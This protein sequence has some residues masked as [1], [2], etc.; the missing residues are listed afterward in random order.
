[1]AQTMSLSMAYNKICAKL[2]PHTGARDYAYANAED[3]AEAWAEVII[4]IKALAPLAMDCLW[5]SIHF[6]HPIQQCAQQVYYTAIPLSPTSSPLYKLSFQKVIYNQLS[7]ITTFSGAPD[8]WGLLLRTIDVRPRQLTCIATSGQRIIAACEEVVNIYNAITFVLQQSLCASETVTKITES[9]DGSTLFFAH[10]FTVTMWDVQTGG[11]INTFTVQS[12]IQDVAISA[13]HIACGSSDGSIAFWDI[14]T[15]VEGEGFQNDQPIINIKWLSPQ[16]LVI[17]TQSTLYIHNI[18]VGETSGSFSIPGCVWGMVYLED[19][20]EFLVG[21]S[22]PSSRVGQGE[23]F[24]RIWCSQHRV[25]SQQL[26]PQT[27]IDLGQSPMHCGQLLSPTLVGE[28][29]V[30]ISPANGVQI[31]DTKSNCWTNNPPL[32]G[33]AASVA[34]SLSRNLVVQADDSI[35]IFSLDVMTSCKVHNDVHSS[36]IYSL[37]GKYIICILQPTRKFLLL[38]LETLQELCLDKTWPLWLPLANQSP[39]ACISSSHGLVAGFD[40]SLV[41]PVWQSGASLPEWVEVVKEDV[42]LS[43]LSPQCTWV[44]TIHNSPQLELHVK[45]AKRGVLLANLPLGRDEL[46]KVYSLTFDSETRFYLKVDRRESHVQIPHDIVTSPSGGYS[47]TI[48]KGEP[49]PLSEPPPIPPYTLDANC[50]WVLDSKSRKICWISPGDIRKGNGGHFWVGLSLVMLGDDGV[51]RK[52]TFK[53][54]DC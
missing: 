31:F 3:N 23:C 29:I 24:I 21:I 7:H 13:T 11:L 5:L 38:E 44:I 51:V 20:S 47:H 18:V 45:D 42:Q 25:Q 27:F 6:F 39:F 2:R 50:E 14:H 35:Q 4:K 34:V 26:G 54:P 9:V 19:R 43:G 41:L 8:T 33:T 48:V 30:C 32:L 28:E 53:D 17:A 49:V 10:S 12:K 37:G 22:Q 1:M 40:I 15:R 16:E 46:G 52:L 36:H